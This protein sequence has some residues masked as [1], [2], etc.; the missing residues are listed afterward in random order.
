MRRF[1]PLFLCSVLFLT[2][3]L[4][5]CQKDL[6]GSGTNTASAPSSLSEEIPLQEESS[7]EESIRVS[8]EESLSSRAE[9]GATSTSSTAEVSE[10]PKF[11]IDAL[12][13]AQEYRIAFSAIGKLRAI[14][15]GRYT[16]HE[17]EKP[18]DIHALYAALHANRTHLRIPEGR[19]DL[20]VLAEELDSGLGEIVQTFSA[21]PSAA[22]L[23]RANTERELLRP[24][25][26]LL[27]QELQ[28]A[29]VM[30]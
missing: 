21:S 23:E 28:E 22:E 26:D 1:S 19:N 14:A 30:P 24:K 10:A 18:P 9:E 13:W 5:G 15:E 11:V 25:I 7:S 8:S 16:L 2:G 27:Y 3:C 6:P 4:R 29:R 20:Q 12:Q 17:G